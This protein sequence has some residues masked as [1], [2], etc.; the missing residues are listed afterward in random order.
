MQAQ[1]RDVVLDGDVENIFYQSDSSLAGYSEG[2]KEVR[3]ADAV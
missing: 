2:E 3:G 1:S